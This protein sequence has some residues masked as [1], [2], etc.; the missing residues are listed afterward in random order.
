MPVYLFCFTNDKQR[1]EYT[2]KFARE[3]ENCKIYISKGHFGTENHKANFEEYI[4]GLS[5]VTF[6]QVPNRTGR[7]KSFE[8]LDNYTYKMQFWKGNRQVSTSHLILERLA[9]ALPE[10]KRAAGTDASW[11]NDQ[12]KNLWEEELNWHMTSAE[13]S[14]EEQNL[15]HQTKINIGTITPTQL[16]S[17]FTQCIKIENP[18]FC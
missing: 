17:Q 13:V 9:V 2:I 6:L 1:E 11:T 3:N 14:E 15:G 5:M 12:N 10:I 16:H 7:R 8:P 4:T 18:Y